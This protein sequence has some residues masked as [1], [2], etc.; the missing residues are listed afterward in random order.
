MPNGKPAGVRC[1][2]LT[3][4]NQ[5]RLFGLPSRPVVCRDFAPDVAVCGTSFEEAMQRIAVL[6][7]ASSSL[8]DFRS[9]RTRR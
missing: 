6:E 8:S 7:R 2:Q 4:D 1:V 3:E 5:C 9:R